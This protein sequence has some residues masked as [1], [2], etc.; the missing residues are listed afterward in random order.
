[1]GRPG[2]RSG[3]VVGC[4]QGGLSQGGPNAEEL[5]PHVQARCAHRRGQ[6]GLPV[7]GSLQ[8]AAA[9]AGRRFAGQARRPCTS[10]HL[11]LRAER[12]LPPFRRTHQELRVLGRRRQRQ[13]LRRRGLPG[14]GLRRRHRRQRLGSPRRDRSPQYGHRHARQRHLPAGPP[15]ALFYRGQ[16]C[17]AVCPEPRSR[18]WLARQHQDELSQRHDLRAQRG[19]RGGQPQHRLRA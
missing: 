6:A 14:D 7:R 2:P 12:P 13:P 15:D 19:A 9:D 1:M 3:S 16:P 18:G 5:S 10:S 11:G 8:T 17:R 4:R